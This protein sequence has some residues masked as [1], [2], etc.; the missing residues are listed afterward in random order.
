EM[1]REAASIEL[2]KPA[3]PYIS[4]L[5]GTW[6]TESEATDPQYW[7]QHLRNTVRF[8]QGLETL[9]HSGFTTFLEVGPG[10]TLTNFAR[11]GKAEFAIPSMRA[12]NDT[13][14][15]Q[16]KL[17]AA[18]AQLWTIG[19]KIDWQAFHRNE[20]RH[21]VTLPTYQFERERYRIEP[22]IERAT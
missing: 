14:H 12:I 20:T 8:A 1:T 19:A 11:K 4:N 2:K 7:S 22:S 17:L 21:R 13:Q 18:A 10:Q 3:I 5:T 9:L 6:I 15:D 16:A